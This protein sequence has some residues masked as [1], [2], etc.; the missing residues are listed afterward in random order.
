MALCVTI[1]EAECTRTVVPHRDRIN[2][3]LGLRIQCP[4][5]EVRSTMPSCVLRPLS[6]KTYFSLGLMIGENLVMC[7]RFPS[8]H[9]GLPVLLRPPALA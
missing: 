5:A 1:G 7:S 2:P 4:W 6:T 3:L 9:P 8:G